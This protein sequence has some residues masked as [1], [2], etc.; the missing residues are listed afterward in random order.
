MT[1]ARIVLAGAATMA[2]VAGALAPLVY[3]SLHA[4]DLT[5]AR[6]AGA[7]GLIVLLFLIMLH[8]AQSGRPSNGLHADENAPD[9]SGP[10]EQIIEAAAESAK[11]QSRTVGVLYGEAAIYNDLRMQLGTEGA[12]RAME[13]TAETMRAQLRAHDRV[14]LRPDGSFVVCI[15]RLRKHAHLVAI[16]QKL[17]RALRP[18]FATQAGEASAGP[19]VVFGHAIYPIGGYSGH[20][21]IATARAALEARRRAPQALSPALNAVFVGGVSHG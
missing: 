1:R 18:H 20:E 14:E 13:T 6:Q 3:G 11:M 17:E 5:T 12:R 7:V 21:M 15:G 16:A 10:I 9:W 8:A 19:C 2:A 4:S